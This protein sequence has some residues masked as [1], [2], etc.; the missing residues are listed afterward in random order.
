MICCQGGSAGAWSNILG[1]IMSNGLNL[2]VSVFLEMGMIILLMVVM[3]TMIMM[4]TIFLM[5]KMYMVISAVYIDTVGA[6]YQ[7]MTLYTRF[8]P[9]CCRRMRHSRCKC[10]AFS[11][12]TRTYTGTHTH[13]L[14][15]IHVNGC[16]IA[17]TH[18]QPSC[19]Q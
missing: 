14:I 1:L 17:C 3:L 13:T 6:W 8:G 12:C 5:R 10:T 7:M 18:A 9:S 11:R 4:L 2:N 19:R 16:M 15:Q